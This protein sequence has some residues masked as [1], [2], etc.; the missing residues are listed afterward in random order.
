[1]SASYGSSRDVRASLATPLHRCHPSQPYQSLTWCE[2]G[3]L[4]TQAR[5]CGLARPIRVA[6]IRSDCLFPVLPSKETVLRIDGIA[7]AHSPTFGE[8]LRRG[9]VLRRCVSANQIAN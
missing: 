8:H 9:T 4:G 2:R 3:F 7:N 1:V 5:S 6:R